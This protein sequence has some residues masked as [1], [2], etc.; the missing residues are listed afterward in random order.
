MTST[1]HYALARLWNGCVWLS[2][3]QIC[4][5]QSN[6]LNTKPLELLAA[7]CMTDP[8]HANDFYVCLRG[9]Y[10][11]KVREYLRAVKS[12]RCV[13]MYVNARQKGKRYSS[14]GE[15]RTLNLEIT[16]IVK[17]SRASQLC[18]AGWNHGRHHAKDSIKCC[19][20]R[21]R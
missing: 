15:A 1:S 8:H 12:I 2:R 9:I 13:C 4:C 20:Q 6:V 5:G 11:T 7:W 3:I 19:Q 18:H 10:Q 16:I 17:V 14:H 21:S